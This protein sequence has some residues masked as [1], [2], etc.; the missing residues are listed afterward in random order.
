MHGDRRPFPVVLVTLD[1]EEIGPWAKEHGLPEDIAALSQDP[2][3]H[4]LIQGMLD[5]ANARATPRSS[6]SRSSRSSTT[7]SRRRPAS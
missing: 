4:E 6:R 7:T 5:K 3:V 1:P 2:Q